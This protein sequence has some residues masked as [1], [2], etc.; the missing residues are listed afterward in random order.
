MSRKPFVVTSGLRIQGRSRKSTAAE[1]DRQKQE[2]EIQAAA[3]AKAT[4]A[5]SRT[6]GTMPLA[7]KF[8]SAS[9]P[10]PKVESIIFTSTAGI[11]VDWNKLDVSKIEVMVPANNGVFA[12]EA[13]ELAKKRGKIIIPLLA[14]KRIIESSISPILKR[15]IPP[16]IKSGLQAWTGTAIIY[17]APDKPFEELVR[18]KWQEDMSS[19]PRKHLFAQFEI[20]FRVPRQFRG[21]TNCALVIEHP[22]FEII[23]SG[24]RYELNPKSPDSVHLIETFPKKVN[25]TYNPENEFGIP[26]GDDV[27]RMTIEFSRVRY[28]F[29]ATDNYVG[30][31]AV[32]N[33]NSNSISDLTC[34]KANVVPST[35]LGV[36]AI[37]VSE[38][39]KLVVGAVP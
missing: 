16:H 12:W 20:V 13:L 11:T 26:R 6:T 27:S 34:I 29:R 5:R 28:L 17:E 18:F 32:A 35:K 24:N 39:I 19:D 22:N 2:A 1:L 4:Q 38:Y 36:L 10:M 31:I 37:P 33:E 8:G 25:G 3:A 14:Y 30:L 9:K 21:K 23:N 15:E 7:S